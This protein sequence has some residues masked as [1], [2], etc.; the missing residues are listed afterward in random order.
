MVGVR[1][2]C[3]GVW[4]LGEGDAGRPENRCPSNSESRMSIKS[5]ELK[6][7]VKISFIMA[8]RNYYWNRG[9]YYILLD[10]TWV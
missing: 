6:G 7:M 10:Y 1:C 2:W 5:S 8:H 9:E 4:E 3:W